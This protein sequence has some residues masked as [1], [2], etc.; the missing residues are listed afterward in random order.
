MNEHIFDWAENSAKVL[1]TKK[2]S[3]F[4]SRFRE[5]V[6]IVRYLL[7]RGY[8]KDEIYEAWKETNPHEIQYADDEQEKWEVFG[9]VW[10]KAQKWKNHFHAP[11]TLYKEEIDFINN[12]S[13]ILWIKQYVLTML[14]VYKYYRQTWCGY[15]NR[16]KCFCYAQT[17]VKNEREDYTLKMCDCLRQYSPYT[18]VIHDSNVAFKMNF[19]QAY[20]TSLVTIKDPTRV[21]ELFGL[22]KDTRVCPTCGK[23]FEVTSS[24]RRELC[25]ECYKKVRNK[26]KNSYKQKNTTLRHKSQI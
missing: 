17:Y 26:K 1:E 12:M 25:D 11:I 2:Y 9:R 3:T 8:Q 14:C 24:I 4:H 5:Q 10:R 19:A 16:I 21:Q 20:G 18:T 22:L 13:V 23:T 6:A 7:D 15:T